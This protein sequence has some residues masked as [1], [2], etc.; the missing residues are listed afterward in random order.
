MKDFFC[1]I[2]AAE[3]RES[4]IRIT[5]YP[6]EP[7]LVYPEKEIT[8]NEIDEIHP[9][10]FPPTLKIGG[11]LIFISR[12]Q[13]E[14]LK[15]FAE[16]NAIKTTKRNSNW[17]F[18]TEPFLDTEFD[19]GQKRKTIELLEKNGVP[20]RETN[21]LRELVGAA[22]YKYN[23]DT[24]LWEWVNLGLLDVLSAMRATLSADE[25]R[26]FYRRALEIEQRGEK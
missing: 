21:E 26:E 20:E 1:G 7:S 11:D 16:R 10:E 13:I 5:N 9:D 25:F 22:M 23:F 24:M 19:E 12:E 15:A 17:N 18:I 4:S 2:G 3:I 6:F 14:E 8:A